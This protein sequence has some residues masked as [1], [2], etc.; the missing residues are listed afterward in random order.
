MP[1]HALV[2]FV[3]FALFPVHTGLVDLPWL[4]RLRSWFVE[5]LTLVSSVALPTLEVVADP[6]LTWAWGSR[7]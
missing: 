2:P 6:F 5:V 3:A 7:A 4:W 1:E